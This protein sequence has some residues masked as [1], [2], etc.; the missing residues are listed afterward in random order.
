MGGKNTYKQDLIRQVKAKVRRA[1]LPAIPEDC[2][3]DMS[4]RS[5]ATF[6][7]EWIT[8]VI[9][10]VIASGRATARLLPPKKGDE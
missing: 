8:P 10:G 7:Q 5:L 9:E 1:G 2:L 4:T 6:L 3:S